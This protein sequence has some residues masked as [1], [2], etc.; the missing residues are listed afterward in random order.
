MATRHLT[1]QGQET[2]RSRGPKPQ[3]VLSPWADSRDDDRSSSPN[4]LLRHLPRSLRL[5]SPEEHATCG[6][7]IYP[8]VEVII[9]T[10]SFITSARYLRGKLTITVLTAETCQHF[11]PSVLSTHSGWDSSDTQPLLC[12]RE[13]RP[14]CEGSGNVPAQRCVNPGETQTRCPG[15]L[16]GLGVPSERTGRRRL[17]PGRRQV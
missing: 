11:Q 2:Q 1:R 3:P 8:L 16:S 15:G 10:G 9:H 6:G 7:S 13:Y 4:P 17:R 14:G 12:S 5:L